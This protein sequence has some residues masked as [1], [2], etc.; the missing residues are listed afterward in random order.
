MKLQK[1]GIDLCDMCLQEEADPE[2]DDGFCTTCGQ[3]SDKYS[4]DYINLEDID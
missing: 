4:E 1:E 3:V 2:R